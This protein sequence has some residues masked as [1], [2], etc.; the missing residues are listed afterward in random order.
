MNDKEHFSAS[1][2]IDVL[3]HGFVRLVSYMQPAAFVMDST[4]AWVRDPDWS[5]DLEVVRSARVSY[6]GD[7]RTGDDEGSDSKLIRSMQARKHTSPKEAMVFTFEVQAPIFVFR[8]WHRH[9]TWSYNETSARYKELPELYYIPDSNQIL[10][11]SKKEKQGRSGDLP[12]EVVGNFRRMI[13]TSSAIAFKNY[14]IALNDGVSR[15]LARLYLPLNT[16]SRMF[17]TVD[18]HNL[19]GFL[20]LRLDEHAQ[21]EIRVYAEALVQL[22]KPIVPRVVEAFLLFREKPLL[23]ILDKRLQEAICRAIDSEI[24]AIEDLMGDF[25][26]S[27]ENEEDVKYVA[28]L[29]DLAKLL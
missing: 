21:Y 7:W 20:M 2:R 29:R 12:P 28:A 26:G 16:Y 22:I 24:E 10:A 8:Q 5:G 13:D 15:E 17:A 14:H 6:Q 25:P 18:L 3:D 4:G 1:D 11:Q 9:R 27:E 23:G 19:L